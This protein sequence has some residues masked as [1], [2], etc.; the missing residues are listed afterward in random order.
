MLV[1][2][3]VVRLE[4]RGNQPREKAHGRQRK[5]YKC[6]KQILLWYIVLYLNH[7]CAIC[8]A[9]NNALGKRFPVDTSPSDWQAPSHTYCWVTGSSYTSV[10]SS[11]ASPVFSFIRPLY[12]SSGSCKGPLSQLRLILLSNSPASPNPP[13]KAISQ[14]DRFFL[15]TT[16]V[17]WSPQAC[18]RIS[19]SPEKGSGEPFMG[20]I[21]AQNM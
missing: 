12:G 4:L 5:A 7:F 3:C 13:Q 10:Y 19:V 6:S 18:A 21:E 9:P 1:F 2:H 11:W 16:R 15:L 20:A 8:G 17:T 14:S